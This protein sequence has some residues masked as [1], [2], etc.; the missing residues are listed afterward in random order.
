MSGKW[1]DPLQRYLIADKRTHGFIFVDKGNY[2][3]KIG[4][5][6]SNFHACLGRVRLEKPHLFELGIHISDAYGLPKSLGRGSISTAHNTGVLN[7]Y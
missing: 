7:N 1:A 5:H 3:S 6:D 4:A 2:Q